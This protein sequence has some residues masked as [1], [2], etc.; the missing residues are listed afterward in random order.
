MRANHNRTNRN[1]GENIMT[2]LE[3]IFLIAVYITLAVVF[4]T[5]CAGIYWVL[6]KIGFIKWVRGWLWYFGLI[7]ECPD[8]ENDKR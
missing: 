3:T 4:F 1:I 8:A 2:T 6:E 5:V 7:D